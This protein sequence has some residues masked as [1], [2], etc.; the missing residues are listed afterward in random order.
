MGCLFKDLTHTTQGKNK[1]TP[2]SSE[3]KINIAMIKITTALV[4]RCD[5]NNWSV[6]GGVSFQRK[7][8]IRLML[9]PRSPS[10]SFSVLTD[11]IDIASGWLGLTAL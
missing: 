5:R 9:I 6:T 10:S 8:Q 7:V 1:Q 11:V 2:S 4:I 3:K